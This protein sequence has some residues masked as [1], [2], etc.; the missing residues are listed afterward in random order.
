[1]G[2]GLEECSEM[3]ILSSAGHR[4]TKSFPISLCSVNVLS[5]SPLPFLHSTSPVGI[6]VLL[7]F[8]RDRIRERTASRSSRQQPC[9]NPRRKKKKVTERN[10]SFL[11]KVG[12]A[13]L[14]LIKVAH[15]IG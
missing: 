10:R 7:K 2:M 13:D 9:R 14:D 12:P 5:S 11:L 4:C 6:P 3:F 15:F 1:M 8:E